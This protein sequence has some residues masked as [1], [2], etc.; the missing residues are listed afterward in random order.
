MDRG[1]VPGFVRIEGKTGTPFYLPT[2]DPSRPTKKLVKL[3]NHDEVFEYL[4]KENISSVDATDFDFSRRKRKDSVTSSGDCKRA[5]PASDTFL[6]GNEENSFPIIDS[7]NLLQGDL[8]DNQ[9]ASCR[10][11]VKKLMAGGVKVHHERDLREAARSLDA[12]RRGEDQAEITEKVDLM[13]LKFQMSNA[14]TIEEMVQELGTSPEALRVMARVI[15]DRVLEELLLLNSTED[16]ILLSEFPNSL[17]ENFVAEVI[18]LASRKSPVTLSF[19]LKLITKDTSSNVEPC[20]VISVATIFSHL[21]S[22]V[23]KSNNAL[24]KIN[25]LQLKMDGLTD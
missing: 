15:E 25:S 16:R 21:C 7:D 6:D 23:D 1:H 12:L 11:D 20:H 2:P 8:G 10:F 5:R 9:Q 24:L 13:G 18:K 22:C 19:L 17:S 4:K 14:R 3:F